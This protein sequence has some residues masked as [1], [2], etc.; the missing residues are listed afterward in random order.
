MR[1]P[2]WIARQARCPAGLVGKTLG[3]IMAFETS[4]EN[5]KALQLL[6]LHS[7]SHV[8]D[9]G[10]GHGRT[11]ARAAASVPDGF[12]AGVDVSAARCVWPAGT[13]EI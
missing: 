9:V 6:G 4:P 8:H 2:Q 10:C 7:N 12:V 13:I 3:R 5:E 1:R 11:L